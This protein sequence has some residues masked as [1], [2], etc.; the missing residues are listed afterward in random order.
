M[1]GPS[2]GFWGSWR[3]RPSRYPPASANSWKAWPHLPR[4]P[5]EHGGW[6]TPAVPAVQLATLHAGQPPAPRD[7]T[8]LRAQRLLDS[9]G[10]KYPA[11]S[12]QDI[13][14]ISARA[15][16]LLRA[17]GGT[18]RLLDFMDAVEQATPAGSHT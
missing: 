15:H 8:V 7:P 12:P 18:L 3:T 4:R 13:A 14:D 16:D 9:L 1:W 6:H 10:G 17:R 11:Y 5:A 2:S